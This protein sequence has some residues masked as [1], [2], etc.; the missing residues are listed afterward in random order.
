M[1]MTQ[2]ELKE[3]FKRFALDIVQFA[4]NLP[5]LPGYRN[6]RFQMIKIRNP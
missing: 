6:V 3:R 5:D 1:P 4:E 2:E